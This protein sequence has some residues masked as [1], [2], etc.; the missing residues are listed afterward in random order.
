MGTAQAELSSI[1]KRVIADHAS[2]ED[3]TADQR[4]DFRKQIFGSL[5]NTNKVAQRIYNRAHK[6][7]IEANMLPKLSA[8]GKPTA[9][10]KTNVA[11]RAIG[12]SIQYDSGTVEMTNQGLVSQSF[13]NKFNTGWNPNAGASGALNPVLATGSVTMLTINMANVSSS[14]AFITIANGTGVG[15]SLVT[16][17]NLGMTTGTN[18][19]SVTGGGGLP[20]AGPFLGAIWQNLGGTGSGDIV[21]IATGTTN[22]QGYHGVTF[23]DQVFL[24]FVDVTGRNAMFRVQGSL[25]ADTVPVELMNF[26][27]E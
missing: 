18:T 4:R 7:M 13:G 21:A 6:A 8:V 17:A 23:N 10:K 14:N 27:V 20:T 9:I 1:Q 11:N 25:L 16:S 3:M 5:G 22:G 12:T 26:S 2:M 24:D 15:A 19:I